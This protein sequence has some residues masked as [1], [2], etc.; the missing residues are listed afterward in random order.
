M[1]ARNNGYIKSSVREMIIFIVHKG[2]QIK[3]KIFINKELNL[4]DN[5][6]VV[7]AAI[8]GLYTGKDDVLITHLNAIFRYVT[9]SFPK[10]KEK[11]DRTTLDNL[12]DGV[13]SLVEKGILSYEEENDTYVFDKKNLQVDTNKNTFVVIYSNEMQKIFQE[14]NKP[15]AVFRFFVL[16]MGTLNV[17]TK[18]WHM[19]QDGMAVNWEYSKSTVNGYFT[20]LEDMKLVY[21]YRHN[22]R[23]TD[24]TYRKINNSYGRYEDKEK[25]ISEA[26]SYAELIATEEDF[27]ELDRRSIKMRYNSFRKGGKKYENNLPLIIELYSDCVLYNKSLEKNPIDVKGGEHLEPRQELDLSVFNKYLHVDADFQNGNTIEEMLD[28]S[29]ASDVVA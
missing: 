11:H 15:F 14:S 20:Q 24:G 17:K 25:I 1:D 27:K 16:L 5:E 12:R 26:E 4:K 3:M 7:M 9:G 19:S 29:I 22:K 8:N 18:E 6:L 21:V 13:K 10:S 2:A 23:R 28:F